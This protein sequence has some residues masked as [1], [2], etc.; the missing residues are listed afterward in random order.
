LINDPT[1]GDGLKASL[2]NLQAASAGSEK[3]IRNLQ[4]YTANLRRPG[5][6]ADQLVTD[7]TV[8]ASLKSTVAKL[9]DAAGTASELAQKMKSTG[10]GINSSLADPKTP[11]GMLL[12]DQETADNLQRTI[13]NLRLS[14][15]E[16][17][18]DLEA[19]QHSWLLR[20]FFKKRDK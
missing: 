18:D 11:I 10:D 20:G 16:L 3:V 1:L 17:A 4:S 15:K 6:L 12:H 2:I 14:S 8:F 5:S 7:T 13:K 19:V 9:N